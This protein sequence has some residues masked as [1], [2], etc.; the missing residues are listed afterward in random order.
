MK[1]TRK[2]PLKQEKKKEFDIPIGCEYDWSYSYVKTIKEPEIIPKPKKIK[3]EQRVSRCISKL[4]VIQTRNK[5]PHKSFKASTPRSFANSQS[6]N[7]V[8]IHRV[9]FGSSQPIQSIPI[10]YLGTQR[11]KTSNKMPTYEQANQLNE[12]IRLS[13]YREVPVKKAPTLKG[14]NP[15][16]EKNDEE[17]DILDFI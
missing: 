11:L 12:K 7:N 16:R 9:S 5:Y 15:F 2:I 10:S 6:Q 1:K 3:V 17:E 8:Q 4:E 13:S 14:F